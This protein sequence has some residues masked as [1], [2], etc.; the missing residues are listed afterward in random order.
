M[1]STLVNL[2]IAYR[3]LADYDKA[4]DILERALNIEEQHFGQGHFE[5]AKTITTLGN[6][7]GRL[8]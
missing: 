5:V 7:Y 3:E 1:A 6:V 8:W 2:G 4:K